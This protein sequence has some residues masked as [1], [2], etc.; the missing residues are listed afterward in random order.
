LPIIIHEI[1]KKIGID[2][3]VLLELLV[4]LGIEAASHRSIIS[5]DDAKQLAKEIVRRR[6]KP[7]TK[8]LA[9]KGD[10]G[11]AAKPL[12]GKKTVATGGEP[13]APPVV[14][15]PHVEIVQPAPVLA[16]PVAVPLPGPQP[17]VA[18]PELKKAPDAEPHPAVVSMPPA[19]VPP[20]IE[21]AA[22][23][24][25]PPAGAAR[26]PVH[27]KKP[28]IVPVQPVVVDEDRLRLQ[29]AEAAAIAVKE[30]A[31]ETRILRR[32]ILPPRHKPK[33]KQRLPLTPDARPFP[34]PVVI[35]KPQKIELISP[36]T[37]RDFS[38]AAGVKSTDVIRKLIAMGTMA[39][40]NGAIADETVQLLGMEFGVEVTMMKGYDPE[41]E[42]KKLD[43]PTEDPSKL[44]PR[45]P[46][47]TMLGHVDHGKTS[48][49]DAIRHT[50]VAAGEFGG[51]TQHIGAYRVT[52][53][54]GHILTFLDTP[55]HEAFTEMRAR[56]ANV[57][58]IVVLVVAAD[59]GVMPQTVEAVNHAKAANVPVVVAVNK[60]DK[61]EAQPDRVKRQ[62]TTYGLLAEDWGGETIFCPVSATTGEGV[63]HLLEMLALQAE[64]LELRADPT[65]PATGTVLEAR[66]TEGRGIVVTVLVQQGTLRTGDVIL[67]GG[68]FGRM[69]FM[70]D[71]HGKL[72]REASPSVAVE[73]SGFGDVP[74]AGDRFYVLQEIGKAREI[75]ERRAGQKR[76]QA[77]TPRKH[78][79][80]E[81]LFET[82]KASGAKELRLILKAD[83]QGSIE[84]LTKTLTDLSVPEVALRVIHS[85]VGGV[86]ESDVLLADASDA[87]IVAFNVVAESAAR[88]QAERSN[89]EIRLYNIIYNVINDMRAA[90]ENR[91]EPEYREVI[92]G[93]AEI[94]NI[95]KVSKVGTIAGCMVVDGVIPRK[96]AIRVARGGIVVHEGGLESLKHF[97]DDV[98][99]VRE[100]FECGMKVAGFDDIKT[101]DVIEAYETETVARKLP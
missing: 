83:V 44:V 68:A 98:R 91:L 74:D 76:E 46:V 4:N 88:A 18:P 101:G 34:R 20:A 36:T 28:A 93:H 29:I 87:I 30:S 81:N 65:R 84:V 94:R 85:G 96:A 77:L 21:Q 99:E 100:G 64:L 25:E 33:K 61:G 78:V 47:V 55:G 19:K 42:L 31:G 40:V 5:E 15:P 39:T 95:F 35:S 16:G 38:F 80:L 32:I 43:S 27:P 2:S 97:K 3:S 82:V 58:D 53:D 9:K 49:L 52:T 22:P 37:V 89:V 48:L 56:G 17:P 73:V 6:I 23:T 71:D 45:A 1:S 60:I 12:K 90:L 13:G 11:K 92:R 75:A 69:R 7:G 51:I 70:T 59:D 50:D 72:V 63:T 57:T 62:L 24:V 14:T 67:A 66:R 41:D 10:K 54:T 26:K 86:N 8:T 79:S